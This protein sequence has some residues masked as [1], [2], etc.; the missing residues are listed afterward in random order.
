M[1][2]IEN[3]GTRLKMKTATPMLINASSANSS[4]IVRSSSVSQR[5][6]NPPP[7]TMNAELMMLAAA[8]TRA[9]RASG[10]R[11]WMN[12]ISGTTYMPPKMPVNSRPNSTLMLPSPAQERP[13]PPACRWLRWR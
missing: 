1:K 13:R 12:A 3:S 7:T 4:G 11:A 10:V 8:M 6:A 5:M 2:R 9:R